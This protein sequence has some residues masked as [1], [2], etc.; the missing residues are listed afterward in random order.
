MNTVSR[1]L[2][3]EGEPNP[4]KRQHVHAALQL[5]QE[6]FR[7]PWWWLGMTHDRWIRTPFLERVNLF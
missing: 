2:R 3:D 5:R 6:M 7:R 4:A 1:I